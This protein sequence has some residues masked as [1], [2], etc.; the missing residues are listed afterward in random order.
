M[1]LAIGEVHHRLLELVR[2]HGCLFLLQ[3]ALK[4]SET[5]GDRLVLARGCLLV[6]ALGGLIVLGLGLGPGPGTA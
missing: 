3:W 5:F 4:V 1:C 2:K 6:L